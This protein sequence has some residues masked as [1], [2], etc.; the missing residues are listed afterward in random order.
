MEDR[1]IW[2]EEIKEMYFQGIWIIIHVDNEITKNYGWSSNGES[3]SQ[4]IKSPGMIVSD[5][6]VYKWLQQGVI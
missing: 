2:E 3:D 5:T 6:E 1:N 4:E